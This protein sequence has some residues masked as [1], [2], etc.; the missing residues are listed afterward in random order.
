MHHMV[1]SALKLLLI[2]RLFYEEIESEREI[3]RCALSISPIRSRYD[4]SSDQS[5]SES[6]AV[7]NNVFHYPSH[8]REVR[9]GT[10]EA[11]SDSLLSLSTC[12]VHRLASDQKKKFHTQF[13]LSL[14][15]PVVFVS[16]LL[17]TIAGSWSAHLCQSRA[18]PS[19]SPESLLC[20]RA[21]IFQ[22]SVLL[23]LPSPTLSAFSPPSPL[24]TFLSLLP[25]TTPAS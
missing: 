24:P 13:P 1:N 18:P 22:F 4:C 17:S 21:Q 5:V 12:L 15:P 23:T 9:Y 14:S 7:N 2:G 20:Q 16:R 8:M 11:S 6:F 10:V 25:A 3:G 19:L